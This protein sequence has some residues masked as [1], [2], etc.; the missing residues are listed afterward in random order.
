MFGM[1]DLRTHDHAGL[2]QALMSGHPVLPL[3]VLDP[4]V[5]AV[6]A[7]VDVINMIAAALQD[8]QTRLAQDFGLDL[9]IST[10]DLNQVVALLSEQPYGGVDLH[11]CDLDAVDNLLGY[12]QYDSLNDLQLTNID[13]HPWTCHLRESPWKH[14]VTLMDTYPQ[15][16]QVYHR[17]TPLK[18]LDMSGLTYTL[19]PVE[20]IFSTT[21]PSGEEILK[22]W[23]QPAQESG[24]GL[25]E[26]HWGGLPPETVG[27]THILA[28]L[29]HYIQDCQ[30]D[31]ELW[32]AH[33]NYIGRPCRR[34]GQSLEHAS[35]AWMMRGTGGPLPTTQNLLEGES[36]TRYL[37]APLWLGTLSPRTL[38]HACSQKTNKL[39]STNPLESLVEQR[40][41]HKLL[42]ARNLARPPKDGLDYGY[43]RWHGFLCRYAKKSLTP[44]SAKKGL[45]LLH[46]FGASSSQWKR[47]I[48]ALEESADRQP[49]FQQVLAPDLIGFGQ[50]E[51]PALTYTQYLWT[52][53]VNDFVK[54]VGIVE[55]GWESYVIGGNSIGGYTS[56][57]AAADDTVSDKETV[58]SLGSKGTNKC[59]GLV[60]FNSAGNIQSEEEVGAMFET[61]KELL[62]IAQLTALD[63]LPA[64]KPVA[65]PIA[66]I[67]GAALL[68]YLRPSIRSICQR[69]YPTN[70]SAVDSVLCNNILRDSLD[71][72]AINVMISG[73]K[74]PIPRTANELL[75]SDFGS[76]L[77]ETVR[78][79][80]KESCWTG[81]VLV[82]QGLLDPLNDAP[83][84]AS[85]L[86]RL[87]QGITV[88]PVED[89][90][91]CPHDERPQASIQALLQWTAQLQKTP[92]QLAKS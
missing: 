87:R 67:F 36:M 64:C 30:Q 6:P 38:W 19:D 91:H 70:P 10:Q 31:D 28:T 7:S 75:A 80:V 55:N 17:E 52:G 68:A 14:V 60:L 45:L 65:R 12:G 50:C 89:G 39:F 83:G 54:Q 8:L 79:E 63:A 21:I 71:P 25:Y 56:M 35:M 88:S 58:S 23:Q 69:V 16:K 82:A 2:Q 32:V 73:S 5:N 66:R 11:V 51:K 84:R 76:A 40:E 41:W 22:L 72:G 26:T 90:G 77:D 92:S 15:Y 59:Q 3:T 43:W 53:F 18:P 86:G 47:A 34:Q 42:A 9:Q 24:T 57:M 20:T 61:N 27:E 49:E 74:L 46:G 13:I 33:P 78:V 1:G 81:P 85:L 44:T 29:R 48:D 62:T 4:L 37:A